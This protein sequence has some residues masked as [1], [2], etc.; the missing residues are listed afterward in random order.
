[1]PRST[2]ANAA[3]HCPLPIR[4]FPLFCCAFARRHDANCVQAA[5]ASV[6][7]MEGM[8]FDC[9]SDIRRDLANVS[10]GNP[11]LLHSSLRAHSFTGVQ[12]PL[13]QL[14]A[15]ALRND[16]SLHECLSMLLQ[17]RSERVAPCCLPQ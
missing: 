1:M 7:R 8:L 9:V 12:A 6:G 15:R 10:A 13:A 4:S 16:R 17:V 2:P 3:L 5:A 14:S 11:H